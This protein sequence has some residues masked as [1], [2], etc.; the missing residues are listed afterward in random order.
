MSSSA[1]PTPAAEAAFDLRSPA[2]WDPAALK[3]ELT[4]QYAVCEGCRMCINYCDSFRTMLRRFDEHDQRVEALTPEEDREIVD[5]CFQCRLCFLNC[6]YTPP[7]PYAID[8]PRLF[9]RAKAVQARQAGRLPLR[10]RLLS[11][12]DR[13]GGLARWV[14][15]V[16][17]ALNRFRPNR[18]VMEKLL[19]IHRDRWLPDFAGETF[20]D[21]W[22]RRR[23]G[24][25]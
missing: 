15:P 16:V 8:I 4:R 1:S 25:A 3:A 9:L 2:F 19:G 20:A 18:V 7:H 24:R 22:R 10:E 11:Q 14:A 12:V 17:N 23:G 6:P 21:W 13:V 5:L